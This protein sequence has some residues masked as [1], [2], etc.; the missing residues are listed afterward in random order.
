MVL[1]AL[2]IVGAIVY[3]SLLNLQDSLGKYEVSINDGVSYSSTYRQ[4]NCRQKKMA[5]R[6][7]LPYGCVDYRVLGVFAVNQ[8]PAVLQLYLWRYMLLG[9]LC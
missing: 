1:T 7:C 2:A 4:L 6:T 8:W 3:G 9:R 5:L